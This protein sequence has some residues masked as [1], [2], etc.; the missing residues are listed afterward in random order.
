MCYSE[1]SAEKVCEEAKAYIDITTVNKKEGNCP[2]V[3]K[4]SLAINWNGE[5]SPCVPLLHSYSC[6]VLGRKKDIKSYSIGNV[7]K[8]NIKKLWDQ[9]DFVNFRDRVRRFVFSPC[10][11][12]EGCDYAESNQ[13]DCYGNTFPVCGDCLWAQGVIQ[14]P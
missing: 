10:S 12:C 6:Y 7:N 8:D 13:E 1:E 14:C 3:G 2:F 4:G 11:H 9:E 5:V